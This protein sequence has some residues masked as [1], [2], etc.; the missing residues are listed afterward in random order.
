MVTLPSRIYVKLE[1]CKYQRAK[2]EGPWTTDAI[3]D[4]VGDFPAIA[5]ETT[6]E[7][8]LDS[9]VFWGIE[10]VGMLTCIK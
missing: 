7:P 3:E 9:L 8:L 2:E 10:P 5:F 4:G 6:R 1:K